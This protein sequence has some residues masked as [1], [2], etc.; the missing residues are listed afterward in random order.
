LRELMRALPDLDKTKAAAKLGLPATSSLSVGACWHVVAGGAH[1]IQWEMRM[2]RRNMWCA[3]IVLAG[4][5]LLPL[6]A[7]GQTPPEAE[8]TAEQVATADFS[9]HAKFTPA[10][11]N[12]YFDEN[13]YCVDGSGSCLFAP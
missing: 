2:K 13:G 7:S 12:R 6:G 5:A 4:V 11:G 3:R 8:S 9:C 1:S 10:A